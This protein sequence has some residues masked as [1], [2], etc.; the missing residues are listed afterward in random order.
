[1][2]KFLFVVILNLLKSVIEV[3]FEL[4]FF[5]GK[6]IIWTLVFLNFHIDPLQFLFKTRLF[7]LDFLVIT[8]L[9]MWDFYDKFIK[10]FF[11]FLHT[12][13]FILFFA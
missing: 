1:M 13:N 7:F 12:L 9:F 8:L 5:I 4:Y 3:S 10:F 2:L 11:L 6:L